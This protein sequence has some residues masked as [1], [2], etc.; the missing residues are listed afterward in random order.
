MMSGDFGCPFQ[1]DHS[2]DR[3][4][5][6]NNNGNNSLNEHNMNDAQFKLQNTLNLYRLIDDFNKKRWT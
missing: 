3:T 1:I 5:N 2:K 4:N 6:H